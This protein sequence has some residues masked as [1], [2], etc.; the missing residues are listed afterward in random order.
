MT[1]FRRCTRAY[2]LF[3]DTFSSRMRICHEWAY[4]NVSL[5]SE[6]ILTLSW[7]ILIRD[8]FSN[9]S[10]VICLIRERITNENASRKS[11]YALTLSFVICLIR[12]P[13]FLCAGGGRV[14]SI[15]RGHALSFVTHSHVW[16]VVVYLIRDP[17]FLWDANSALRAGVLTHSWHTLIR[18]LF[19]YLLIVTHSSYEQAVDAYSALLT[20]SWLVF[21]RLIRGPFFLWAGGGRVF[22]VTDLFVAYSHWW[23]N[24]S[25]SWHILSMSRRRTRIQRYW[26]IRDIF[27]LVTQYVLFVT[28]SF[29]EQAADAYSALRA[30]VL[31][32]HTTSLIAHPQKYS[33]RYKFS[34]KNP[35]KKRSF[36]NI[37]FSD[38]MSFFWISWQNLYH[39]NWL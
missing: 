19:S 28:H 13:F 23:L 38:E 10:F 5:K 20:H 7:H 36:V 15:A 35:K 18:D 3:R 33:S 22:S 17:F 14:I 27:S 21:I 37:S 11:E 34:K 4:V 2:S 24:T 32:R 30:G 26:L 25:H 39:V 16:F 29:Y 6:C 8:S 31:T 1:Q 12:D 9:V